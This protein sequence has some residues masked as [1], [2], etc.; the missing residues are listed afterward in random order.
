MVMND[1]LKR[2]I[3]E[4]EYISFDIFDTLIIRSCGKPDNVFRILGQRLGINSE[5]FR[6]ARINAE[7]RVRKLCNHSEFS[8]TDIYMSFDLKIDIDDAVKE[9]IDT[10]KAVCIVNP[11]MRKLYQFCQDKGKKIILTS[12]M[13]LPQYVIENILHNLDYTGYEKIFL[14]STLQKRNLVENCF[15]TY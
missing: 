10:E 11:E 5:K 9:E 13:Y 2:K 3:L 14:S 4:A 8:L 12:D 6:Q 15:H 7:K 1:D